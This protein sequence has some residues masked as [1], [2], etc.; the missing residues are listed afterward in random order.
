MAPWPP[1]SYAAFQLN[2]VLGDGGRTYMAG[3]SKSDVKFYWHKM[4]RHQRMLPAGSTLCLLY[5]CACALTASCHPTTVWLFPLPLTFSLAPRRATT[6][7]SQTR[8][9]A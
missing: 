7:T 2:Y 5:S 6:R 1:C 3:Y 9:G 4:V 8:C